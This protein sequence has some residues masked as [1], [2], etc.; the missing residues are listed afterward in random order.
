MSK[1]GSH[2]SMNVPYTS[3]LSLQAKEMHLVL[4]TYNEADEGRKGYLNHDDVK[5]AVMMLFG[6]K[7]SKSEVLQIMSTYGSEQSSGERGLSLAQF[8]EAVKPKF[9]AVDEDEQIRS[10]FLAFDKNCR[11]FLSKEDVKSV[12]Q[13]VCPHFP[14]HQVELAFKEL[15]RDSDGRISYKD[16]DFMMKFNNLS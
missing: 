15:D 11:G 4:K 8:T 2:N 3:V 14:E 16:F 9:A 12:F 10:T 6:H 7:P 13:Q 5:V 1:F